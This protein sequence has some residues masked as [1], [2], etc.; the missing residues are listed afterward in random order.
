MISFS[1]KVRLQT[2][3]VG[4]I[5]NSMSFQFVRVLLTQVNSLNFSSFYSGLL[6][7]GHKKTSYL[8][9]MLL[10]YIQQY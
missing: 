8:C 7:Y 9:H 1:L 4:Q 5:Q 3:L 10:F 2:F 6:R